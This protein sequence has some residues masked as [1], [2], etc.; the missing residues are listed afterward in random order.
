MRKLKNGPANLPVAGM[1]AV[2]GA[3]VV[4][5]SAQPARADHL[6]SYGTVDA[7]DHTFASGG[8]I[9]SGAT[10]SGADDSW[11]VFAA[12]AGD[13]LT[14]SFTTPSASLDGVV[15][16]EVT[17]GI[18]EVGDVANVTNFGFNRTGAGTD[19]VVQHAGYNFGGYFFNSGLPGTLNFTA[20]AT[21]QYAIGITA[22]NE[23]SDLAGPYT[24]TLS[25]NTA[26]VSG[27]VVPE[28]ST[29][30]LLGIGA[31]CLVGYRRKRRRAHVADG[32]SQEV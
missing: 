32:D 12:N 14:V 29:F 9:F 21:G 6:T 3:L 20:A 24:V 27:P 7:I 4:F 30:A 23:R 31:V 25:G 5:A 1:F 17:N 2:L 19:L 22:E 11:L 15:F 18:V 10:T 13:S 16:R 28:P 8:G 26:N